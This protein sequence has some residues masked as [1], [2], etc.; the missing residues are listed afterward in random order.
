MEELRI[1]RIFC[2][3]HN[4]SIDQERTCCATI[5]DN[6][7]QTTLVRTAEI[8]D[9]PEIAKVKVEETSILWAY[10]TSIPTT[11]INEPAAARVR[12]AVAEPC[13]ENQV[14]L[15][16]SSITPSFRADNLGVLM[17]VGWGLSLN[18]DRNHVEIMIPLGRFS[19]CPLSILMPVW[20]VRTHNLS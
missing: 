15:L 9:H 16:S 10:Q 1:S 11:L 19:P 20:P 14:F 5:V 7:T 2:V 18:R 3:I 4:G 12:P 13:F 17:L 8:P 6:D